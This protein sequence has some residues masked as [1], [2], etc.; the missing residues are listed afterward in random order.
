MAEL[1][2]HGHQIPANTTTPLCEEG[3]M[4]MAELQSHGHQIPAN[5]TAP[6]CEEGLMPTALLAMGTRSRNIGLLLA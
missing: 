2:S 1:R 4:P 3:L 6:L 5:T